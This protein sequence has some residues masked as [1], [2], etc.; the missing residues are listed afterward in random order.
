VV[1]VVDLGLNGGNPDTVLG[2]WSAAVAAA[3]DGCLVLDPQGQI[4]SLSARAAELLDCSGAGVI[5]RRLI[6]VTTL[7]DFDTGE[8]F[9]DYAYRV[10]PLAA[11]STGSIARSLIRVRHQDDSQVTLD[12][13]GIPLHDAAGRIV[14]SL[15]FVNRLAS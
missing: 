11:L 7:I 13:C 12:V 14:G 1:P 2:R 5:G 3:Q 15:S 10:P 8:L 4:V 6:D 9:P